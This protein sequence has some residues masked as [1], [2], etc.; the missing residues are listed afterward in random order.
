[1]P[2][3]VVCATQI[4][5]GDTRTYI[6]VGELATATMPSGWIGIIISV[7]NPVLEPSTQDRDK[8]TSFLKSNVWPL[9][10]RTRL[11]KHVH[12]NMIIMKNDE[13]IRHLYSNTNKKNTSL[14]LSA[15]LPW[16]VQC[17]GILDVH[18]SSLPER[19]ELCNGR[20]GERCSVLCERRT[21]EL[22]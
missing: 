19:N 14:K 11:F 21:T 1:M 9:G 20:R 18:L 8:V 12:I 17:D 4:H 3:T 5:S 10:Y 2:T 6:S 15:D 16:P 13:L 22:F 7:T